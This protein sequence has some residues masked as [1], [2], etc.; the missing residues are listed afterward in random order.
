MRIFLPLAAM[1]WLGA[2]TSVQL[3]DGGGEVTH[4]FGYV[5]LE[6]PAREGNVLAL[7]TES[8]G[9]AIERGIAI[10]WRDSQIVTAAPESCVLLI[11]VEDADRFAHAMAR[12]KALGRDDLCAVT[13]GE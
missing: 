6:E 12:L 7:R 4:Y 11:T 3:G 10:G 8:L 13:F 2:C 5:R 9:I 1:M